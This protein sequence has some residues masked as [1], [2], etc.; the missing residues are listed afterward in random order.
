MNLSLAQCLVFSFR[1][2]LTVTILGYKTDWLSGSLI[3]CSEFVVIPVVDMTVTPDYKWWLKS[4][5]G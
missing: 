1:L 2:L 5:N 4:C 3:P